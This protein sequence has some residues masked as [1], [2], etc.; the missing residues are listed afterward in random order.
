MRRT[1]EL[2]VTGSALSL[3]AACGGTDQG[4]GDSAMNDDQTTAFQSLEAEAPV[5]DMRPVEIEQHGMA[6]WIHGVGVN[7]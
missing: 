4:D 3:L 2:L 6:A 7:C 5:A 1:T